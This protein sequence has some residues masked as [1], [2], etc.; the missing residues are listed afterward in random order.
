MN[1]RV[2]FFSVLVLFSGSLATAQPTTIPAGD[3]SGTWDLT[4]SP[5]TITGNVTIPGGSTLII[6]PGVEVSVSDNYSLTVQGLLQAIGTVNDTILFTA[7]AGW[8][9]LSF[10]NAQD[11]S[12][13]E[14][15]KI[16]KSTYA[17]IVC[18]N[19]NPAITHCNICNNVSAIFG[20]IFLT[21]HSHPRIA[22]CSIKNNS[23]FKSG[24]G[25]IDMSA[26]NP[27]ISWCNICGNSGNSGGISCSSG[28]EP[29][30]SHCTISGNHANS[31]GG[32]IVVNDECHPVINSCTISGNT[33]GEGGGIACLSGSSAT[34]TGCL[35]DANQADDKGGG[36][37][38][39]SSAGD[40]RIHN[41]TIRNSV[42]Q[43]EGGGVC[44][45]QADSVLVTSSIF[46]NNTAY[47][48]G[49]SGHGGGA[50]YSVDCNNLVIDHCIFVNNQAALLEGAG[51]ALAGNTGMNL[52]NSIFDHQGDADITFANYASASISYCDFY[53][54]PDDLT[55]WNNVPSG[56]GTLSGMNNNGDS[57]DV[58]NNL[59][60][61]PL[62]LDHQNGDY[63]LTGDSP[64]IDA[65]D[66]ASPCDPDGTFTDMGRYAFDQGGT[67]IPGG[68][69]SGTWTATG[70][71]YRILGNITIPS[72]S[73]LT[74]EPGVN[75]EFQGDY[76]L[77]VKGYLQAIGTEADSIHFTTASTSWQGIGFQ[78]APDTSHLVYC[79]IS[80]GGGISCGW[81]S[82]PV[83]S[84]CTITSASGTGITVNISGS[85]EISHCTIEYCQQ[86]ISCNSSDNGTISDCMI[87]HCTNGGGIGL[88]TDAEIR[89]IDCTIS[90]NS[91][92]AGGGG[93]HSD[94]AN[95]SLINC[96]ISDNKA[97]GGPGGGVYCDQDEADDYATFT[98]CTING[99]QCIDNTTGGLC[100]GAIAIRG[101]G[102]NTTLAYCSIYGNYGYDYAG[103]IAITGG[104]LAVDH[105]TIDG[106]DCTSHA[107]GCGISVQ[108]NNTAIT[109]NS[110]ISNNHKGSGIYNSGSMTVGHTDFYNNSVADINGTVPA[111]FGTLSTINANGDSC[112]VYGNL[113]MDPLFAD[114]A[115][116]DFHLT[117][118]SP[119]INAGNPDS[120]YDPDGT[121]TD[122]GAL[123]FSPPPDARF[124]ADTT[125]GDIPLTVQFLD[126][127]M[128]DITA[129][130]W[131]FG[132]GDSSTG[133]DPEHTYTIAGV[134]TVTLTVTGPEGT[135]SETKA[136]YITASESVGIETLK[137]GGGLNIYPNPVRGSCTISVSLNEPGETRMII[138]NI[139]GQVVNIPYDGWM[140][141]L[142]NDL[143]VDL[144]DVP[145]GLYFVTL[146]EGCFITRQKLL[147]IK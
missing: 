139:Q 46:E 76:Q 41:T 138:Y 63:H 100:G 49:P 66:P 39:N 15:C 103:G 34:I 79:S 1:F 31:I 118:H 130:L 89:F 2:S 90:D 65:G 29:N 112:D 27:E 74:I 101:H 35:L 102:G 12:H 38:I 75:V 8:S 22:Y 73:T 30:I 9:G 57:C 123:F 5:Y 71:P 45:G 56:L 122:M 60:M 19:S 50:M 137:K 98:N 97:V 127:S 32:G 93:I 55:F 85:P 53:G 96:I 135:D 121:V 44:I 23:T 67:G 111:G 134:Y 81:G 143:E 114:Q 126:Q 105:C 88:S 99:N 109:T 59:Y 115:N 47:A 141:A 52:T 107:K 77:T 136:D 54:A 3:V 68:N 10:D 11:S 13:L 17:G 133:S 142:K 61:D 24:S 82:S 110:I 80:D 120:L 33:A 128:G 70:S 7:G 18:S 132:D 131:D 113:Y 94:L 108:S 69:V 116:Y 129:W 146:K 26:S 117:E 43:I 25:G 124:E 125:S 106:N 83:L 21:N 147:I 28:S 36:I 119:C 84:H 92:N 42:S 20:G 6:E 91:N 145:D 62:F 87:R 14:Y 37:Y 4:G 140:T 95:L 58:H 64:C 72:G 86:G 144:S 51:I 78:F 104:D 16:E 40:V 48:S